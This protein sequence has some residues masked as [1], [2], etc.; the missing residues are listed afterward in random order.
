MTF[1]PFKLL[2]DQPEIQFRFT[3]AA[4]R[5]L[6]RAS[7]YGIQKLLQNGQTTEAI[8]LMTCYGQRHMNPRMTEQKAI[9]QIQQFVDNNGDTTELFNALFEALKKSGVYGKQDGAEEN[10]TKT[11]AMTKTA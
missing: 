8:V 1:V 9:D 5:D 6:D 2:P 3:I 11:T 4:A 10:P 7:T